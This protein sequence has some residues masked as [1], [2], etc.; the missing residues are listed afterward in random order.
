VKAS[1][2][3]SGTAEDGG[4]PVGRP[5]IAWALLAGSAIGLV[6]ALLLIVAGGP[7]DPVEDVAG[8]PRAPADATWPAGTRPAPDFTLANQEGRAIS[9]SSLRGR[10]VLLT[11]LNSRCKDLCRI[12][13]PLLGVVQRALPEVE[14]P[15]IVVVSVN[16][17]DT[18]E[19][20]RA[21]ARDWGWGPDEWHWLMGDAKE[22]KGVWAAYGVDVQHTP[23]DLL[24]SGVLYVID[25]AGDERA[26]YATPFDQQRVTRL[27]RSL[28][29]IAS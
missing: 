21:A 10:L 22:L 26:G 29:G 28:A 2:T 23:D 25:R 8:A 5:S 9:L 12:E 16:P 27:I 17:K 18:E 11:F 14:R 24:H 1:D 13:G 3:A 7:P 6:V 19:S 20:V 15:V 4:R